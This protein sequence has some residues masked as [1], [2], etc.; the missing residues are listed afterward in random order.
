MKILVE[1]TIFCLFFEETRGYAYGLMIIAIIV[2]LLLGWNAFQNA[3][4]SI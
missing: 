3:P 2:S 1:M 4:Q